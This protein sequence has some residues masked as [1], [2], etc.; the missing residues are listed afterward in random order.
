MFDSIYIIEQYSFRP[1]TADIE[2]SIL[3]GSSREALLG[4]EGLEEEDLDGGL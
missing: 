1:K 4:D 3:V 2:D